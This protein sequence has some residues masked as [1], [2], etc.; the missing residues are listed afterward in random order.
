MA[1]N[2]IEKL[3]RKNGGE[4]NR[5]LKKKKKAAAAM[6]TYSLCV[7]ENKRKYSH[8]VKGGISISA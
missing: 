5:R 4:E 7:N 6:A 1:R 3:E 8:A 2:G